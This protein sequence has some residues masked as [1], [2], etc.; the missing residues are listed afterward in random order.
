MTLYCR[1][2]CITYM[3]AHTATHKTPYALNAKRLAKEYMCS[4]QSSNVHSST[5]I[6][7]SSSCRLRAAAAT[8]LATPSTVP[9]TALNSTSPAADASAP[10]RPP[11]ESVT[12]W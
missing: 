11:S 7:S 9:I 2:P 4:V 3:L 1:C 8:L 5:S 10:P 6:S 12:A